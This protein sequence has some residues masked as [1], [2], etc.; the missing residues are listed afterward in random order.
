MALGLSAMQEEEIFPSQ[1]PTFDRRLSMS[2]EEKSFS[3]KEMEIVA[4][5]E[6]AALLFKT[7]VKEGVPAIHA[8]AMTGNWILSQRI[9]GDESGEAWRDGQ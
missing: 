7:L 5:A 9:K 8:T 4:L 2:G 3:L 1:D 6:E